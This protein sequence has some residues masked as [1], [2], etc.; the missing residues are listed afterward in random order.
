MRRFGGSGLRLAACAAGLLF[1]SAADAQSGVTLYG[2]ID[3]GLLYTSK[4][5]A[6]VAGQSAGKQVSMI[7]GGVSPSLFGLTGTEDL[8]D[9][10]IIS[11]KLESG[12]SV[13]N[14][15]LAD[16]NGNLFGCQAW[17]A[18]DSKYGILKAGL[19]YSPFFLALYESDPRDFALFGSGLVNMVDSVLGTS[20]YNPNALSYTSP[21][22]AGL[23]ASVMYAFG[24]IPGDFPA[25]RQYAASVKYELGG[26][27]INASIYDGNSGGNAQTPVPTTLEFEGRTIGAAYK[28]G[29]MTAKLS[30][31]NYKV[32]GSFN[33][34]VYG[35]GLD[36]HLTP[37]FDINGGIWATSDRNHT[38]NHSV[39]G[40]LGADYYLSKRTML[41]TQVG[42][43]DN[44]GAMNTGI[45]IN[46]ALY[47]PEGTTVG[48]VVGMR[49]TF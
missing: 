10:L 30:F 11:F 1:V 33:N 4:T 7:E 17:I 18:L 8:G 48:A 19:Q 39:M 12:F 9:G 44:H 38:A 23:Q 35:G 34:N 20:I 26:F 43:V 29:A 49:H 32:A 41:Y 42:V 5:S 25:G 47:A 14:G 15:A 28:I 40:A 37:A 6:P 31:V 22:I 3:S 13:A 46:S 21:K 36:Y 2:V 45:S 27:M 16:C 24:G